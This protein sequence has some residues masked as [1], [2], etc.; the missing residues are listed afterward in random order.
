MRPWLGQLAI[1]PCSFQSALFGSFPSVV[2][3]SHSVRDTSCNTFLGRPRAKADIAFAGCGNQVPAINELSDNIITSL[4]CRSVM[5][6]LSPL[7]WRNST[8]FGATRH[9]DILGLHK[10]NSV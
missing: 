7:N 9:A 1:L 5:S 8:A 10:L 4:L 3:V 6:L 2:I